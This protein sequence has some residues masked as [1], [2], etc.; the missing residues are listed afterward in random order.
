MNRI[1]DYREIIRRILTEYAN[2]PYSHG[3]VEHATVF[4]RESDR[5]LLTSIGW[6][7][8]RRVYG[9]VIQF[10]IIDGKIWLQ[11]ANTDAVVADDL[12]R[13]GVTNEEIVLGFRH[14]D[15]RPLTEYAVA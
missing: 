11:C 3:Q 5:Y 7:G 1:D 12:K 10:D 4:D 14:P 9:I 2:V 8:P 13:A 6:D 15:V